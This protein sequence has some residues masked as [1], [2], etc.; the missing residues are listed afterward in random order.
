VDSLYWTAPKPEELAF[1]GFSAEE[2]APPETELWQEN[3]PA[4]QLFRNNATQWR[5]GM[6]GPVGLDYTVL[7]HEIDRRNLL[8]DEYDDLM[9]CIRVIEEAALKHL[10]KPA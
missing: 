2:V 4:I 3:W 8:P 6:G 7:F 9:G 5:V 1:W 10:H